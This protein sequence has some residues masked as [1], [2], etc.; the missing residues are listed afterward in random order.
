MIGRIDAWSGEVI[1]RE[2]FT[3]EQ[4]LAR[5][6]GIGECAICK[7]KGYEGATFD[8]EWDYDTD[9]PNLTKMQC[10]RCGHIEKGGER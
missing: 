9:S 3:P 1:K 6:Y 2:T 7:G 5:S 4:R 8:L 10:Q